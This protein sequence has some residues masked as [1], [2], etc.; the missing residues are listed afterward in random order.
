PGRW[1]QVAALLA[2]EGVRLV[3]GHVIAEVG[4]RLDQAAIV[5][6]GAVPIAGEKAR[7]VEGELHDTNSGRGTDWRVTP[8][9]ERSPKSSS[10]RCAQVCRARI[11]SR[12]D[13]ASERAS[14]ES[15]KMLRSCLAMSSPLAAVR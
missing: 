10:T 13:R 11:V 4:K 14:S 15:A 3:E 7:T 12:P 1:R 9:S 6:G 8:R 2:A 5:S